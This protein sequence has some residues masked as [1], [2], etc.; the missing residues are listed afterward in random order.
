MPALVGCLD[1]VLLDLGAAR[2]ATEVVPRLNPMRIICVYGIEPNQRF[3]VAL[4]DKV[5]ASGLLNVYTLIICYV[6]EARSKLRPRAVVLPGTVYCIVLHPFP[7]LCERS[8][9]GCSTDVYPPPPLKP[10]GELIFWEHHRCQKS[11]I[12]NGCTV[13]VT[14]LGLCLLRFLMESANAICYLYELLY[15]QL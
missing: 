7:M 11:Y 1:G 2:T 6:E 9:S 15:G 10:G 4:A 12:A 13:Y 3:A 5:A 8:K 14:I